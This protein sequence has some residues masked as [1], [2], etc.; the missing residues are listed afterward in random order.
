MEGEA[1]WIASMYK[2]DPRLPPDQQML[3]THAKRMA[4]E[5]WEKE[6]KVGTVYDRD[7]RPLNV[8]GFPEQPPHPSPAKDLPPTPGSAAFTAGQTDFFGGGLSLQLGGDGINTTILTSPRSPLDQPLG[9]PRSF[10]SGGRPGTSSSYK[11]MPSTSNAA[12]PGTS[13]APVSKT[14]Q[15]V[16]VPEEPREDE[17]A[18][19][20]RKKKEGGCGCVVM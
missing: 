8:Q 7:F 13:P 15:P 3:P 20:K 1:P 6:G 4:Q 19:E 18:D 12:G 5:Q 11:L 10:T 14:A 9:S 16:R 17:K 2:P